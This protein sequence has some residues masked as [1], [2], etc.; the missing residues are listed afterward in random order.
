MPRTAN[1]PSQALVDR[2]TILIA[3]AALA[4]PLAVPNTADPCSGP[5]PSNT[6]SEHQ[7]TDHIRQFY[8]ACRF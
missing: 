2:R 6:S 5:Q 8:A 4:T 3:S 1:T 7:E